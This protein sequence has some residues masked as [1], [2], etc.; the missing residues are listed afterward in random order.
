MSQNDFVPKLDLAPKLK[1]PLSLWNPLDYLRLLYWS[2]FFPQAFT[3]YL[4][5]YA[6]GDIPLTLTSIFKRWRIRFQNPKRRS[7]LIQE[8]ILI[9]ATAGLLSKLAVF[10]QIY[11]SFPFF[12]FISSLTF[13]LLLNLICNIGVGTRATLA[14]GVAYGFVFRGIVY[15]V[16]SSMNSSMISDLT[17]GSE[18]VVVGVVFCVVLGVALGISYYVMHS[19]TLN[20]AYG[21]AFGLSLGTAYSVASGLATGFKGVAIGVFLG[22]IAGTASSMAF[23]VASGIT[24][25]IF[26]GLINNL[27]LC[28]TS[29]VLLSVAFNI[30]LGLHHDATFGVHSGKLALYIAV[31]MTFS[32]AFSVAFVTIAWNPFNWIVGLIFDPLQSQNSAWKFSHVTL[33]PNVR[34]LSQ[35]QKWL[36]QDWAIGINNVN[37]ILEYTWQS[38]HVIAPIERVL[39]RFPEEQVIYR[40]NQLVEE[41]DNC[42]LIRSL[43]KFKSK[44]PSFATVNGFWYL[45]KKQP[46][47]AIEAFSVVR[48]LLYGEE[49]FILAQTLASFQKA[50]TPDRIANLN[51][52]DF[53]TQ[54]LLRTAT[55]QTINR[56]VGVVKDI[57]SIQHGTCD[58]AKSSTYSR[59]TS[60][61]TTVIKN[62][63]SIPEAERALIVDIAITWRLSLERTK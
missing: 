19:V 34:L 3:W 9:I 40:V 52:P 8:L 56:L 29:I 58:N 43:V 44:L 53:P 61:L 62:K 41:I 57:K 15:G 21:A 13:G 33:L 54:N 18:A 14:C 5:N 45:Y 32:V 36:Q 2:L 11:R 12:V 51:V 24:R 22:A 42:K 55:W 28:T 31:G 6:G 50:E 17:A 38:S 46:D 48:N 4:K 35:L 49:V 23:G 47:K 63:D 16:E 20:A 1:R 37:Q 26:R 25:L 10:W 7:L 30:A 27:F 39:I 60:E 59:A